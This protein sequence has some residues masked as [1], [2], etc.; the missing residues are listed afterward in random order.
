[1]VRYTFHLAKVYCLLCQIVEEG[2][3]VFICANLLVV[4]QTSKYYFVNEVNGF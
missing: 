3:M 4:V 1:M 2:F